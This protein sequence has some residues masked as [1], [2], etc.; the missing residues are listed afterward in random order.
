MFNIYVHISKTKD[1]YEKIYKN[2]GIE[3]DDLYQLG[4]LGFVKAIKN[5][6]H[7]YF[8]NREGEF[9]YNDFSVLA[10]TFINTSEAFAR[11]HSTNKT[12]KGIAHAKSHLIS[13]GTFHLFL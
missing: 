2:K 4:C 13:H 6:D 3:Y 5:F 1:I 12:L 8:V 7:S 11:L 10:V 9:N